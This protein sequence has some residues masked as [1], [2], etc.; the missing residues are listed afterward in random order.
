VL[1]GLAARLGAPAKGL[2]QRATILLHAA[3]TGRVLLA[4]RSQALDYLQQLAPRAL[5]LVYRTV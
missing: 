4:R 5:M 3:E 2:L 1:A